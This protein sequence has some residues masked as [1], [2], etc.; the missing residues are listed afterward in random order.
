MQLGTFVDSDVKN[1]CF[2]L[3]MDETL[4]YYGAS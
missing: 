2:S 4:N 3:N 1:T